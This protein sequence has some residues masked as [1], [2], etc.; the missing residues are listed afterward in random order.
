MKTFNNPGTTPRAKG[1]ALPLTRFGG[2]A[3]K[4]KVM[5]QK[6]ARLAE[7][8]WTQLVEAI[9]QNA[10]NSVGNLGQAAILQILYDGIAPYLEQPAGFQASSF[11]ALCY[12]ILGDEKYNAVSEII[13]IM[14]EQLVDA[15]DDSTLQDSRQLVKLFLKLDPSYF[16][17][18]KPRINVPPMYRRTF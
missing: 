17:T 12:S 2:K 14:K 1:G 5:S 7:E 4:R 11:D 9:I 10:I 16:M 13:E 6:T 8:H 18:A 15:W 3:N